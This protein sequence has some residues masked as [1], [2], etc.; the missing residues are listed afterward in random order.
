[1]TS[2]LWTDIFEPQT[3]EEIIGQEE[4]VKAYLEYV[5][6][7]HIPN[8]TIAGAPG[9][10]KTLLIKCFATNLGLIKFVD[11]KLVNLIP[12][13]FYLFDASTDRG[14]DVVRGTIKRLSEKPT[15]GDM[16]RLIVLDE[17][18]YTADAQAAMRSLMQEC[19]DNVRFII[20]SNDPSNIIDPIISRCPLKI[21]KPLTL[22]NIKT[23]VERI[24]KSKD[25]K[26]S[27]EAVEYLFKITQGDIRKFIGQ[28]Q[29]ACIISNFNVQIQNVQNASVDLQV[30]KSILEAAQ[31]NYDQAKEVMITIYTKTRNARDLLEK[32]YMAT[33]EVRFSEV[34]PDNEII[35]RRL[36]ERIAE[37][38]FRLSP[39]QGTNPLV[40]LD[41][42]INYIRLLK[43][44]PLQCP[45][46]K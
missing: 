42:V 32:M 2:D 31:T 13:Q 20:L 23:L 26:I 38:D 18:N 17:F 16:P 27:P 19:S 45:K 29:D 37:A 40:Q 6:T 10:G 9:C 24:Q 5:K 41:A 34:M 14:I 44:I 8:M 1:M 4:L 7:G 28:L 33:Y 21:A 43:F 25:F 12:G 46:A 30:A 35:Q 36:R 11:G 39:A 15:I 3:L 22:E